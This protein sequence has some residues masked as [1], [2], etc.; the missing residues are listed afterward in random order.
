M[1]SLNKETGNEK[2]VEGLSQMMANLF[3]G[4]KTEAN[5]NKDP[6]N[7]NSGQ[8]PNINESEMKDM[9]SKLLSP[10]GDA[11]GDF[12]DLAQKLLKEFMDKDVLTEPL[13]EAEKSYVEYLAKHEGKMDPIDKK[14][15][16][17]QLDC[18]RQ[19]LLVLEKEPENKEKMISLFEKM[20]DYGVPP[21]GILNPL[22]KLGAV[23]G[24]PG[25]AGMPNMTGMP[26][27]PN[28]PGMAGMPGMQDGMPAD[29]KNMMDQ[30]MNN[31]DKCNIF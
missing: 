15:Y 31:P 9:F 13:Q 3:N 24:M 27:M 4:L 5:A 20:H 25:M 11:N 10:D 22:D 12:D 2:G 1:D 17:D 19:L 6:T 26:G 21:E 8:A 28:M 16:E 23:P 18:V 7:P 14:R 29:M 30:A